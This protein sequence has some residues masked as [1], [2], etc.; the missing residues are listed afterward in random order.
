MNPLT[1][2]MDFAVEP[3][4]VTNSLPSGEVNSGGGG[5][6]TN[7]RQRSRELAQYRL[8][9]PVL[10]HIQ[11]C[12]FAL[13]RSANVQVRGRRVIQSCRHAKK[14]PTAAQASS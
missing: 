9:V 6:D 2:Q 12:V 11:I 13:A 1:F 4:R 14:K 3:G 5:R 8:L 10:L 7:S